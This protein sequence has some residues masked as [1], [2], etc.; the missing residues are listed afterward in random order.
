MR[1]VYY[2]ESGDDGFPI[3]S[4]PL[5]CLTATYMHYLSWK[6]NF[7]AV[8]DIRRRLKSEFNFPV[9]IEFHTK[10]FLLDKHPYK[11]FRGRHGRTV[12]LVVISATERPWH[13][14]E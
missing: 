7:E 12:T 3:Y 9:K 1:I 11:D 13:P 2:D 5:F 6:E 4:S 8:L 10:Y 14:W